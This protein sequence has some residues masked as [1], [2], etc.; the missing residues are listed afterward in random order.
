VIAALVTGK[1]D[2]ADVLFLVAFIL[3][4]VVFVLRWLVAPRAVDGMLVAAGL[5]L[6]TLAFFVL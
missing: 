2:L 1:V 4:C 3:F 5:A 6:T